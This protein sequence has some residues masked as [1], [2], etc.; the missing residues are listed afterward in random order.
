MCE[1]NSFSPFMLRLGRRLVR[2]EHPAVMGILNVTLDSFYD[3]G[4]Y[5][6][7]DQ[8]VERAVQMVEDGADIIDIGA[9]ST[10]P[11]AKLLPPDEESERLVA[12]VTAV[13]QRLPQTPISVDTCFSLPAKAAVEA[14]AD[15]VNDISGGA[16]DKEMFST[17]AELGV[18]YVLMH[19]LTTPDRMQ[20]CHV[21]TDIVQEVA[22]F[23]SERLDI[24]RRL[25]VGDVIIDPGFGFSKSL[26]DNYDLFAGLGELRELFPT[27]PLLVAISRKSMIYKLLDT[28]PD[29]ALTGTVALH[30][31]ALLAGAQMLR[32]HDV[33]QARQTIAVVEK[34]MKSQNNS[35]SGLC[36]S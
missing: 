14:G 2:F 12:A 28:N 30:A 32:A 23:F 5:L 22:Y 7:K 11:G 25:G 9:V 1:N 19:N 4:R 13:R 8:M 29:E 18:P 36:H 10:R 20:D 15:I 27:T 21:Y 33:K 24:L 6:G 17:V 3:G 16:F 31:A 26:D 34:L 35:T